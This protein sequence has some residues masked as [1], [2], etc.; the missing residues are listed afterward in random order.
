MGTKTPCARCGGCCQRG[1]M[2]QYS[3]NETVKKLVKELRAKKFIFLDRCDCGMLLVG[4][5]GDNTC[6]LEALL[7][8]DAKPKACREYNC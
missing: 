5:V 6:I 3:E 1:D 7:G 2:W 8:R 4:S